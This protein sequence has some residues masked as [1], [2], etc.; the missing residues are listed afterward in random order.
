MDG[1]VVYY[2]FVYERVVYESNIIVNLSAEQKGLIATG[3]LD[4]IE[5]FYSYIKKRHNA[6]EVVIKG[7]FKI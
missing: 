5:E 4:F 6:T 1:Y 7:M 2:T 3:K